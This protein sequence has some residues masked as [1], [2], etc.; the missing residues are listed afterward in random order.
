MS[1]V[2]GRNLPLFRVQGVEQLH[3]AALA[4]RAVISVKNTLTY[5]HIQSTDSSQG[6]RAGGFLITC[7]NVDTG[8]FDFG[9]GATDENTIAGVF[10][11]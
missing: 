5:C 2:W 8:R 7:G 4:A 11:L 6:R 1:V 10:S 3:Q 9:A